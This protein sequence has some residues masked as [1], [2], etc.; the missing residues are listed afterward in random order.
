MIECCDLEPPYFKE[1]PS[2]AL[3]LLVTEPPPTIKKHPDHWSSQLVSFLTSCLKKEPQKRPQSIE[4]IQ[5]SFTFIS[6][7]F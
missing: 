3:F 7:F 6:S 4:L 5:V 2:R 1:S